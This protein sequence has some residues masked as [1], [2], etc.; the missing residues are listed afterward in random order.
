MPAVQLPATPPIH[1]TW[2]KGRIIGQK[3]PLLPKLGWAIR[4]KL[5]WLG[6]NRLRRKPAS[7]YS[8]AGSTTGPAVRHIKA[9]VRL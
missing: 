1:R 7:S 3:P 5:S 9:V 8:Q 2:N 4:A 6:S